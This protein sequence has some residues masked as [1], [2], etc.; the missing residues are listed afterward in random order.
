[1]LIAKRRA[2]CSPDVHLVFDDE[3]PVILGRDGHQPR[4]RGRSTDIRVLKT[5][6]ASEHRTSPKGRTEL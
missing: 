5:I 4:I 3:Q 6:C 1:M 2:H